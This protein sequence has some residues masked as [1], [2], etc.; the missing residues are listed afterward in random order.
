MRL[1]KFFSCCIALLLCLAIRAPAFSAPL[2]KVRTAWM[3]EFEAFPIWY[4]K[5]KGWD[6]E[7]GLDLEILYFTSGMAILN[8]LP[9]G[10]WQYAAIGA[11]PAMMG[12]LR[13]NT[14]VIANAD[15]EFLINRV[16]VR[17]DS[18]IA[19][20]KGWNK[21]YPEV[22]GSPETVKGKTFLTTT[23][24][25]AHYA[26]SVWLRVLGLTEKDIVLKN[27]DQAQALSAYEDGIGDGV[28]L[29]APHAYVGEAKGW[30]LVANPKLCGRSSPCVIVADRKYADANPEVT[31]RFLSV[32]MRA[33]NMLQNEPLES[34]VPE[35]RRFFLEWAGRDYP[36]DLALLD[37]QTHPVFNLDEQLA[38][39]DASKGQS[40][41]QYAQS[42]MAR[43]FAE[44]GSINKDELKRVEDGSYA[45]DKY[46][47]T[48]K[49]MSLCP[50]GKA[51]AFPFLFNAVK[52]IILYKIWRVFINGFYSEFGM[53]SISV[54]MRL[55][56]GFLISRIRG[57][58]ER[59]PVAVGRWPY[60]RTMSGCSAEGR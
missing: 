4:A 60:V 3:D 8:A 50:E 53:I 36:A 57:L 30:K 52:K 56:C 37:L 7:A 22:L 33:M 38:M 9:S 23:V 21:D 58:L 17:P 47:P 42:E 34:L 29:W 20:V 15:E 44:I 59:N 25:S 27:M 2:T 46:P 26:L 5:E 49:R 12:A 16:L 55:P 40:K 43:F 41:A 6:K 54:P 48:S 18:P 31:A 10:E 19:K 39:F 24:S 45:T 11:V 35:Y 32:Y 13:Y 1:R 28:C 51:S 14:Y